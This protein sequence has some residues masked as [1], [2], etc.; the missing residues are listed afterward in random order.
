MRPKKIQY[1]DSVSLS[2]LMADVKTD[3]YT[4]I[5]NKF[6]NTNILKNVLNFKNFYFEY[7]KNY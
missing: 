1:R 6:K 5:L 4:E 3:L 7:V 2:A